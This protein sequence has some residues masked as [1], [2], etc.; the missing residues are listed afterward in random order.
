MSE[1]KHTFQAG[2]MNKDLDERLVPRGEYRDALNIEVRTSDGSDIGTA[3]TLYGNRERVHDDSF[4][5]VNPTVNWHSR[6]SRFVGSTTDSKTDKAYFLI[7]SPNPGRF[8]KDKVTELK[9]YKDL[10]VMY[11]GVTK[12]IKPVVTDVF[13][14]E[15]P[16]SSAMYDTNTQGSTTVS[17]DHIDVSS[18]LGELLRPG[19]RGNI[20]GATN[21]A[22]ELGGT[23]FVVREVRFL[24]PTTTSAPRFR[25]FFTTM[26]LGLLDAGT[27]VFEADKVLNFTSD[28]NSSNLITGI[29]VLDNLLFW[30]NNKSEPKKVNIDRCTTAVPPQACTDSGACYIFRE[31]FDLHSRLKVVNPRTGILEY[32]IKESL[33]PGLKEEHIT[34]IRRAPKTSPKLEMSSFEDGIESDVTGSVSNSFVD[35]NGDLLE[36]GAEIEVTI[37]DID[38]ASTD[39]EGSA[40]GQYSIGQSV[41]LEYSDSVGSGKTIRTTVVSKRYVEDLSVSAYKHTLVINSINQ[42]ISSSDTEWT[43]SLEQKKPFFEFNMGRFSHRYKYQDGEYSTFAPWSELAFLPGKQDYVPSKGYNLGM[44]NTLRS[45]KVTNFIARDYHELDDVVE[46]DILYKDTVSPNVRLVKSI[47]KGLD[48]EWSTSSSNTGVI[49]I[50]SEMMHRTLPSSKILN[51]WDNVPRLSK[52]QEVTGNRLIYG[53]YLHGY[54]VESPVSVNPSVL[55]IDHLGFGIEDDNQYL[56]P[57]KSLKSIRDYQVG[58]VFGDK[59]GRETPVIGIGGS[60]SGINTTPSSVP[61]GKANSSSVNQLQAELLW[62]DKEPDSWME[63]YKYYVKETS[64]EY[65]NLVLHRWYNA[66]DGN[67]WLAFASAD[68][69]KVDEQT[70][71]T[72][73]NEHG[74]EDPVVDNARYKILAI[75]NEAPDYIKTTSK[76]LGSKVFDGDINEVATVADSAVIVFSASSDDV[77][78]NLSLT[79]TGFVRIRARLDDARTAVSKWL[80]ISSVTLGANGSVQ[81]IKTIKPWGVSAELWNVLGTTSGNENLVWSAEVRDDVVQNK[82]EFDGRFFVKVLRD[83]V[84]SDKIAG[85][86]RDTVNYTVVDSFN[87]RSVYTKGQTNP[88]NNDATYQGDYAGAETIESGVHASFNQTSYNWNAFEYNDNYASVPYSGNALAGDGVMDFISHDHSVGLDFADGCGGVSDRTRDF[89]RNTD[90]S[91][92]GGWV[93]DESY[94]AVSETGDYVNDPNGAAKKGL[95]REGNISKIDFSSTESGKVISTDALAFKAGMKAGALFRFA[96]DPLNE[97]YRITENEDKGWRS[98]FHQNRVLGAVF[99]SEC[100]KCSSKSDSTRDSHCFRATFTISFLNIKN[101]QPLDT[102]IWDPRSALRH[103]GTSAS[104]IRIVEPSF[105]DG[106]KLD[107]ADGNA[108]WETEPKENVGLDLY[109]EAT[110]A[111]PIKLSQGNIKSYCPTKSITTVNRPGSSSNPVNTGGS[112]SLS[113]VSSVRD[114]IGLGASSQTSKA[115]PSKVAIGDILSFMHP[116]SGVTRASVTDHMFPIPLYSNV[117]HGEGRP[118]HPD[119][120]AGEIKSTATYKSST[121]LTIDVIAGQ[122]QTIYGCTNP[123]ASNYNAAANVSDGNCEFYG[124]GNGGVD[125]NGDQSLEGCTDPDATN[126]NSNASIDN[127]LCEYSQTCNENS[128]IPPAVGCTWLGVAN[129]TNVDGIVLESTPK[130]GGGYE[131]LMVALADGD[132]NSAYLEYTFQNWVD[133]YSGN[134]TDERMPTI[135]ELGLIYDNYEVLQNNTDFEP[136]LI[137]GESSTAMSGLSDGQQNDY[138]STTSSGFLSSIKRIWTN[139]FVYNSNFD[140]GTKSA[141]DENFCTVR[142]V[143]PFSTEG[144]ILKRNIVPEKTL[145]IDGGVSVIDGFNTNE[146]VLWQAM[147]ATQGGVDYSLPLGMFITDINNSGNLSYT[148]TENDTVDGGSYSIKFQKVTGYYKLGTDVYRSKTTLPWFNCYSFGNGLESNRVRDDYNAPQIDNGVKVSTL[149][150]SYGE[151]RRS[152]GMIY[153]GIY[154][155]TSGVNNLNEFNMAEKITKD[156]NPSHGSIQVLKSR[157]T[158]VLAFCEDKVFKVLANKD[159]LYNA[160]GSVNLIASNRVL[161]NATAFS[162]EYGISSNPES[163]AV[164]GYRMYFADK[165]RNKVLRLSQDGLTPISDIGMTSWFRDNLNHG[166]NV[167]KQELVGTFDE[168]KGEYN[169]SL[170]HLATNGDTNIGSADITV[171]FN[172]KSKGWSSFKSFVPEVG[173]SINDEYITGKVARLWSHHDSSVNANTFYGDGL[174][175]STIDVLFNDSPGSVKSFLAMNYEGSQAKVR[176]FITQEV[177]GQTYNDGEFYNLTGKTGWYVDSFNT[178]LQEAQ[179]P[180]F[181]QKEG[182]WFNYI[183]GVETNKN[184]LDTS[185]FS[186]QGIGVLGS[187]TSAPIDKVKLTVRENND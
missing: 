107:F 186:V 53:N 97:V 80:Q 147:S 109:Y 131:G 11:D 52:A 111:L 66:E 117:Y 159:A 120:F 31:G 94:Q 116:N 3:Q 69:N 34:V 92:G 102:G 118:A 182:K 38:V 104:I 55:S 140:S 165:Q 24:R 44:V 149:L 173:L 41:L 89:W 127:G 152:S 162:G 113:V 175:P 78:D 17:Y 123:N 187:A 172:E 178:D 51:A 96:S 134:G 63:Y 146:G 77:W 103:D 46:V 50:S 174:V 27:W 106:S 39:E 148:T 23:G 88:A 84:L 176:E 168:V 130:D 101:N 154:N 93:I 166:R 142:G 1:I 5:A 21:F 185:E 37:N 74:S 40:N 157:D 45:L 83:S 56:T 151:E 60:T 71:I 144:D 20:H 155:S 86:A 169:L 65:Y 145:L 153:S 87:F 171:S 42:E 139:D 43:T 19:M 115:K 150:D 18:S 95:R 32:A 58:V 8:N 48:P 156:L 68:R 13:R 132:M 6:P 129:G 108:I 36:V 161:G 119:N 179:V 57:I 91:T 167:N 164:D 35:F 73:K 62:G 4:T 114:V 81:N 25:V 124:P 181:K 126:Y 141:N 33:D 110:N 10:I 183:S 82:P 29:N 180:D 15:C 137:F 72:L 76:L 75:E 105:D 122:I 184:N 163:L 64:N 7:A 158:N 121:I 128:S 59:Y 138:W 170:R 136:F 67:L 70:Y 85:M 125:G 61:V 14:V 143:I 30:T 2:K 22:S 26:V 112:N 12:T 98:N 133:Y 100:I 135:H 177:S 99:G 9:S 54:N 160:D 49:R 28:D 79:G 16:L 90:Y 47:K